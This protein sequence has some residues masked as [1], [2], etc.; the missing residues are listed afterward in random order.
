MSEGECFFFCICR[1]KLYC[2]LHFSF[3]FDCTFCNFYYILKILQIARSQR[4]HIRG[5]MFLYFVFLVVICFTLSKYCKLHGGRGNVL[6][7]ECINRELGDD[8]LL[9]TILQFLQK[10][11]LGAISLNVGGFLFVIKFFCDI[12]VLNNIIFEITYA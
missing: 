9:H 7:E 10:K 4:Q 2:I 8:V 11:I 1:C 5:R 12:V 3:C 6:E